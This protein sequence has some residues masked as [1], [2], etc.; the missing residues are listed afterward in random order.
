MSTRFC[1][2]NYRIDNT[3]IRIR[4]RPQ[5]PSSIFSLQEL[6]LV[7]TSELFNRLWTVGQNTLLKPNPNLTWAWYPKGQ[8]RSQWSPFGGKFA[9]SW[10]ATTHYQGFLCSRIRFHGICNAP[11]RRWNEL[12]NRNAGYNQ[13][14]I[15]IHKRCKFYLCLRHKTEVEGGR[16]ADF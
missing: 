4:V 15:A 9:Q 6:V 1:R 14:L 12:Q 10:N 16:T 5:L 13:P 8:N 7:K 11:W 3:T 2:F